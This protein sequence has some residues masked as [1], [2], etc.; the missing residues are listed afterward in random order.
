MSDFRRR[1]SLLI[2]AAAAALVLG[3]LTP[4]AEAVT[5][6]TT[7]PK[8]NGGRADF[9]SGGHSFGAPDN[10]GVVTWAYTWNINDLIVAKA[11]VTGTLYWDDAFSSGCARLTIRFRQSTTVKA[12]RTIDLCGPGGNANNTANQRSIDES[13]SSTEID[14]VTVSA[15]EVVGGTVIAGDS[16]RVNAPMLR[17]FPVNI[18]SGTADFGSGS[19]SFGAP[20]GSARVTLERDTWTDNGVYVS[21]FSGEIS[22]T[23]YWDS[24][25]GPGC[26]RLVYDSLDIDSVVLFAHT[27]DLCGPGGD[28]NDSANRI[29]YSPGYNDTRLWKI[30]L[31]VGSLAG[32]SFVGVTTRTFD[33]NG[34]VGTFELDPVE[35]TTAV[36]VPLTYALTWTVPEPQNWHALE[37]LQFR[38]RDESNTLLH[39]RWDEA[40]NTFSLFN[41]AA[42]RFGAE[43]PAGGSARLQTP[44]ATLYLENTSARVVNSPLGNGPTSP[45]V[46]LNLALSFKPSAAER[47]LTVDVAASDDFGNLDP[48]V[49]AGTLVV[50]PHPGDANVP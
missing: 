8:L 5:V 16:T 2:A 40:S 49:E 21:N 48:W 7:Y 13:Y 39:V 26:A 6:R 14:N 41:E 19:H 17:N 9:G 32:T 1:Y 18:N 47:V 50:S 15:N 22:G 4:A 46:M 35:A 27:R 34:E 25:S 20:T 24:L 28:A 45:A 44:D 29:G 33:F 38:I 36:K 37:Y 31:R 3:V 23:L 30:R 11:R 12:T 42:G 43:M 10:G